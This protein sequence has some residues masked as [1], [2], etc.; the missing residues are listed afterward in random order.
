MMELDVANEIFAADFHGQFRF[1]QV[2]VGVG[3]NAGEIIKRGEPHVSA[4]SDENT[5]VFRV[6]V[7]A[8][9]EPVKR[10]G[11][12]KDLDVGNRGA[13]I[14]AKQGD[15]IGGA[16][17][18]F[19]LIF[20]C[21]WGSKGLTNILLMNA[22]PDSFD[23]DAIVAIYDDGDFVFEVQ[24][25]GIRNYETECAREFKA[26]VFVLGM[27]VK[28]AGRRFEDTGSRNTARRNSP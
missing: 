14:I 10:D 12:D 27:S 22:V 18:A 24:N 9:D 1:G 26:V 7:G 17:P 23:L 4:S 8:G 5:I 13:R 28:F 21:M 15:N 6:R 3:K 19:V 25:L 2:D 11:V 16:R 20:S